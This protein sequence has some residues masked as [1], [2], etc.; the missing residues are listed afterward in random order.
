MTMAAAVAVLLLIPKRTR[1]SRRGSD[2]LME[3]VMFPN[4]RAIKNHYPVLHKWN[5]SIR[6]WTSPL[7]CRFKLEINHRREN[8]ET[9]ES[10]RSRLIRAFHNSGGNYINYKPLRVLETTINC[11]H[12]R[13]RLGQCT[14]W[15]CTA[16]LNVKHW[17]HSIRLMDSPL[18]NGR[19]E[20][21]SPN[22]RPNW[23][24]IQSV[25]S[26]FRSTRT[27]FQVPSFADYFNA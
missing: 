13:D 1:R 2:L 15:G 25:G 16:A 27:G 24:T 4:S 19:Q 6:K 23:E 14:R 17:K 5:Q 3:M 21:H 7:G 20:T 10:N 9:F 8:S 11:P 26:L 12:L 22:T 18:L